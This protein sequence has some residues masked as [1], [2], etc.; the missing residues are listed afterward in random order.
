MNRWARWRAGPG[1]GVDYEGLEVSRSGPNWGCQLGD[2]WLTATTSPTAQVI[3]EFL[4]PLPAEVEVGIV[5]RNYDPNTV[6]SWK[7]MVIDTEQKGWDAPL[8][9]H[10]HAIVFNSKSG[11][12]WHKGSEKRGLVPFGTSK[13]TSRLG[14]TFDMEAKKMTCSV[15]SDAQGSDPTAMC[16]VE[17][18][19]LELTVAIAIGPT[20]AGKLAICKLII[21]SE[22]TGGDVIDDWTDSSIVDSTGR[23]TLGTA[24]D[25]VSEEVKM[26]RQLEM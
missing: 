9:S 5:G 21:P 25:E 1:V 12:L 26:A 3:L 4:T 15:M 17:D 8:S 14:F 18:L 6:K 13:L 16:V 7:G 2:Q 20:G 22:D 19:P 24:H 10:K 23:I 11:A